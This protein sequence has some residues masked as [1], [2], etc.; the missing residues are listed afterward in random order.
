MLYKKEI[1]KTKKNKK[2]NK[3]NRKN[4]SKN[5]NKG[6]KKNFFNKTKLLK[7]KISYYERHSFSSSSTSI[8][9]VSWVFS[10]NEAR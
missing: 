2:K 5:L 7:P 6:I 10:Q 4:Q 3:K 1:R 9:S 8:S